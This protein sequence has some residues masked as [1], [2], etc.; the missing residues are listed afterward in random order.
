MISKN[1]L[2]GAAVSARNVV[3]A[4]DCPAIVKLDLVHHLPGRLRLR[5]AELKGNARAG[6]EA[7]HR[8]AAVEGVTSVQANPCTGSLLV[9]Y[10]TTTL[11]P[12]NII[13]VLASHGYVSETAEARGEPGAGWADRLASAVGNWIIGAL[14]DQLALALI[15]ALA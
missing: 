4:G 6:E 12:D 15:G 14:A 5:S 8:L 7:R 2:K 10:N 1:D 3:G 11:S 9:E 13:D